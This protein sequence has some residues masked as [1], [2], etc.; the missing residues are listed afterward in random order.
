MRAALVAWIACAALGAQDPGSKSAPQLAFAP[1]AGTGVHASF[2]ENTRW[3][4]E[5][6]ERSDERANAW[7]EMGLAG[8]TRRTLALTDLFEKVDGG[9][10]VARSRQY[11][12][13]RADSVPEVTI[14]HWTSELP[15]AR[16]SPLAKARVAFTRTAPGKP[17]AAANAGDSMLDGKRLAGLRE[18]TD[19][20]CLL[21]SEG[22]REGASWSLDVPRLIDVLRPGGELA[23]EPAQ[24]MTSDDIFDPSERAVF[25]LCSLSE[26]ASAF[27]GHAKL[28]W[29][30]TAND[31]E[32]E[33]AIVD[34]EFVADA[35]VPQG[36]RVAD[37]L[38]AAKRTTAR[39]GFAAVFSWSVHGTGQL[40]WDLTH[41]RAASFLL[42]LESDLSIRETWRQKIADAE[43]AL[44]DELTLKATSELSAQFEAR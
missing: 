15:F 39:T 24:G 14:G 42:E 41:H 12:T 44:A 20:A 38:A 16:T 10:V 37:L 22:V 31:D 36:E 26:N 13:V 23:L 27:A 30:S 18:D 9:S 3:K 35:R 2:V 29:S 21:P 28:T 1:A 11:E 19:L 17:A 7:P 33:L 5:H 40:T 25:A 32:R 6:I 34:I 8:S 4:L 43:V